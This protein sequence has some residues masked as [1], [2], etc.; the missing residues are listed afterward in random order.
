[1]EEKKVMFSWK[2]YSL[3]FIFHANFQNIYAPFPYG[4]SLLYAS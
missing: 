2:T 3:P 4:T 1:M